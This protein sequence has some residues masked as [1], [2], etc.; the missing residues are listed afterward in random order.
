MLTV[1]GNT[2]KLGYWETMNAQVHE[3]HGHGTIATLVKVTDRIQPEHLEK[4]V[5]AI[6][7]KHPLLRCTLKKDQQGY[8]HLTTNADFA[9][10]EL[11]VSDGN[12]ETAQQLYQDY[13]YQPFAN[14][15]ALWRM[16]LVLPKSKD[17]CYLVGAFS[18]VICDGLAATTAIKE[19]L[20]YLNQDKFDLPESLPFIVPVERMLDKQKFQQKSQ[21]ILDDTDLDSVAKTVWPFQ[22]EDP[23]LKQ[24]RTGNQFY[25]LDAAMVKALQQQCQNRN[26]TF[27]DILNAALLISLRQVKQ[28]DPL[29][30]SLCTPI[31]LRNYCQPKIPNDFLGCNVTVVMTQHTINADDNLWEVAADYHQKV[32]ASI[33]QAGQYPDDYKLEDVSQYANQ[34]AKLRDNFFMGFGITNLGILDFNVAADAKHQPQSFYICASRQAADFAGLMCVATLNGKCFID[35]S[36]TVP[37]M[38]DEYVKSIMKCLLD[39]LTSYL[40]FSN[41]H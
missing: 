23:G 5:L 20:H 40:S 26:L 7:A 37:M 36:Y 25:E 16:A 19:I 35:F 27:N 11:E 3:L 24:R 17:H 38:Q 10:I 39:Q 12:E 4:V 14:S 33:A 30:T 34:C 8:Y 2:R 22:A 41:Q 32:R 13:L 18:H 9:N 21:R 28:I 31:N 29:V 15:Q 1:T 6:F